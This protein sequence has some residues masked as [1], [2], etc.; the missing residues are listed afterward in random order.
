MRKRVTRPKLI[1]MFIVFLTIN[2]SIHKALDI[3]IDIKLHQS[4]KAKVISTVIFIFHNSLSS[5][6]HSD[7]LKV[8]CFRKF[9]IMRNDVDF[10]KYISYN[11]SLCYP[12][13][14]F[15]HV[16]SFNFSFEFVE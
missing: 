3:S 10:E 5:I 2:T 4:N 16:I 15:K 14:L 11:I 7:V 6:Q 1:Q 9:V 12:K 8:T 13:M